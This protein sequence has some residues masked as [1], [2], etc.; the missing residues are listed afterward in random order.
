MPRYSAESITYGDNK[1]F[2][3]ND[4]GDVTVVS[5]TQKKCRIIATNRRDGNIQATP[6]LVDDSLFS[7]LKTVFTVLDFGTEQNRSA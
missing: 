2:L 4:E 7:A 3:L 5:P 1:L 6:A